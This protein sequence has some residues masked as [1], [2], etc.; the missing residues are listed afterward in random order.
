MV[1]VTWGREVLDA[2]YAQAF[3]A[4]DALV[5]HGFCFWNPRPLGRTVRCSACGRYGGFGHG[6]PYD[7]LEE[8][9]G[10]QGK[11]NRIAQRLWRAV[12]GSGAD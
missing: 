12:P 4:E 10:L 5:R 9:I 7:T 8:V 2:V 1:M 3:G 6:K 11:G